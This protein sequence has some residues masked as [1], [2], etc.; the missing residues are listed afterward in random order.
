MDTC[1]LN[2]MFYR[3]PLLLGRAMKPF[4]LGH[5]VVL[6]AATS[7]LVV[8]GPIAWQDVLFATY[9]C[10]LT[11]D[12]L[13]ERLHDPDL[14]RREAVAWGETVGAFSASEVTGELS[15]YLAISSSSPARWQT[16]DARP[17][18]LPWPFVV[19]RAIRPGV[20]LASAAIMDM[21]VSRALVEYA[22]LAAA[23]GGDDDFMSDEERAGIEALKADEAAAAAKGGA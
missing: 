21:P 2:A 8:G 5:V 19:A 14:I 3:P 23:N 18:R 1:F 17:M 20:D 13:T 10:S 7:P 16:D 11:W 22:C 6:L 15:A 9:V 4:A 12:Q